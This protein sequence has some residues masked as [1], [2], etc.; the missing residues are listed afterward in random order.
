METHFLCNRHVGHLIQTSFKRNLLDPAEDSYF[1]EKGEEWRLHRYSSENSR[2]KILVLEKTPPCDFAALIKK[3][4]E[5]PSQYFF[6][7]VCCTIVFR[8]R[9]KTRSEYNVLMDTLERLFADK[10]YKCTWIRNGIYVAGLYDSTNREP[11][12]GRHYDEIM[13]A[14]TFY[15]EIAG[16]AKSIIRA[17]EDDGARE[18]RLTGI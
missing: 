3:L 6:I 18:V 7:G 10:T 17:C 5:A 11:V 4:Q 13:E 12:V 1:D 15:Q 16:R 9:L 8:Y 2:R 14:A